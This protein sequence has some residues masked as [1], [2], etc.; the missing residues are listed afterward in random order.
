MAGK[1]PVRVKKKKKK[2]G[3]PGS[4]IPWVVLLVVLVI[5][6]AG[7]LYLYL[8]AQVDQERILAPVRVGSVD[9][10][11]MTRQ[12]AEKAIQSYFSQEYENQPVDI[13]LEGE[14][15]TV[16]PWDDSRNLLSIDVADQLDQAME[17]GHGDLLSRGWDW[18]QVQLDQA[19]EQQV[20]IHPVLADREG[21]A[22]AIGAT[23]ISQV[24]TAVESSYQ[25]GEDSITITK[26]T[27]GVVAD[28]ETLTSQVE[29]QIDSGAW[30]QETQVDC[31]T[32]TSDIAA[33]DLQAIYD[34]VYVEPKDATL[35]K[36]QDYAIVDS[37]TG[38]SFDR[39]AAQAALDEAEPGSQVTVE[40]VYTQPEITT[41]FLREHLFADRLGSYSTNVSGSSGRRSNVQ[42][43]A[44]FCNGTILLPGETFSYNDVVGQRTKARGFSEAPAYSN[45]QTVQEVGGGICQTSSTLYAACLYANLEI[46]QRVNHSYA[47]SYI[48]L[49]MD[50]TVSWGGP[51]YQF[52]NNT[53]YPIK[54]VG[55]YSGGKVTMSIY[56]TKTDDITVEIT[57]ETL[58]TIPWSTKK[59]KDSSL[60]EGESKVI[61]TPYTGYKV[62]TYRKLYDGAGNLISSE[63]EAYS[64]YRKRDKVIAV[65]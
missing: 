9:L 25:I 23:G 32:L 13:L 37:V 41:D 50:A 27:A 31:A 20:T 43:S 52:T 59:E 55:S 2:S 16:I 14:T 42:L 36:E 18:I 5:A 24:N 44:E 57:S 58:E 54:V 63:P 21:L 3:N 15:Y 19:E 51:D 7:V 10:Q 49:G 47:S 45:G 17:L 12:E 34:E 60:D 48:G 64:N 4:A 38:V 33:L 53:D 65:G 40:L 56:G 46:T 8:C 26:G 28:V 6:L 62:Q 61:T 35:D 39:E 1:A 22:Q 11:D 29:E 30:P